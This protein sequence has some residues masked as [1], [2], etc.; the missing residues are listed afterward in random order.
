MILIPSIENVTSHFQVK[1]TEVEHVFDY[2]SSLTNKVYGFLTI[3]AI[4]LVNTPLLKYIFNNGYATFINKLIAIDCCLCIGKT[5][6]IFAYYILG[7]SKWPIICAIAPP[8]AYFINILN[9][10]LSISIL[11]FRYVFVL[12][13]SWVQTKFQ[14]HRF[15]LILAGTVAVLASG[16]TTL[17]FLNRERYFYFLGLNI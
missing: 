11:T 1:F 6:P 5:I 8:Y 2:E 15:Y 16:L 3:S 10:L 4:L 17:V 7:K 9:C 12:Q 13:S 14:R